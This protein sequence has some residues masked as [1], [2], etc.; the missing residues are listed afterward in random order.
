MLITSE[1][2]EGRFEAELLA[3]RARFL[4]AERPFLSSIRRR[5][6]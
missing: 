5:T 4:N 2:K 1:R 6:K 3:M